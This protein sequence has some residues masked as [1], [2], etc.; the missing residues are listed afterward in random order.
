M[1]ENGKKYF[2]FNIWDID[3]IQA[4]IDAAELCACDVILQTSGRIFEKMDLETIRSF[5][6]YYSKRKGINAYLHLD[7]CSKM[8]VLRQAIDAGWDSV[9]IDASRLSLKENIAFTNQTCQYAHKKGVLVEAEVGL[10]YGVEDNISIDS[11]GIANMEDIKYF[12][13]ET[14]IDMFAAAIGTCHGLY[15]K[16]P[17][18]HYNMIGQIGAFTEIPFVVHGG[19]GLGDEVLMKLLEYENVKKINISTELKQAY[20]QGIRNVENDKYLELN[21]FDPLL[22]KEKIY[23]SLK[24]T[25]ENKMKLLKGKRAEKAFH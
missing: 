21:G 13:E 17:L 25:V 2:A 7:H 10:I 4:V 14:D 1:F 11:E 8:D 16:K 9:M 19:S 12:L 23:I 18:I 15:K 3:S 22:I 6:K 20:I 24:S 5:S